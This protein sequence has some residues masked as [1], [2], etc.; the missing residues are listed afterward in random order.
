MRR[1]K[2]VLLM[3]TLFATLAEAGQ[4]PGSCQGASAATP[5]QLVELY[6][7]EGCDSC[8]PTD[9]WLSSVSPKAGVVAV[10]F[11]V[12]YW[13]RLGWKDR[14]ALGE[15]TQRQQQQVKR[16]GAR[17]AY[18]PQVFLNGLDWRGRGALPGASDLPATVRLAVERRGTAGVDVAWTATAG[19]PP[20]LQFWWALVED[21]HT[22]DVSA[23]ENQGRRLQH[24]SVARRYAQLPPQASAAGLA[25]PQHLHIAWAPLPPS[26]HATR[27][28]IV[29]TD[30]R[31]GLTLQAL[32][33]PC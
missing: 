10:S 33:L 32:A 16:S 5:P 4:A 6:T 3:L 23:G 29:A 28:V 15:F 12:D 2:L 18:T 26:G 24:D 19:A 9:H 27:L 31:T 20:E 1:F 7:S 8:P 14:F 11:H 17:F 21:G 22:S 13:D 25:A 30:P